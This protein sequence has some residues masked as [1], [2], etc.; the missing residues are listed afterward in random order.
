MECVIPKDA[1][2]T[3]TCDVVTENIGNSPCI[4]DEKVYKSFD[5][6]FDFLKRRMPDESFYN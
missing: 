6:R 5:S 4:N 1:V 3:M 2:F